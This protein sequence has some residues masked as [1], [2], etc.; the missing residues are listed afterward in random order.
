MKLKDFNDKHKG[1]T[2]FVLGN[3]EELGQLTKKQLEVISKHTTIGVNYAHL[4]HTPTYM[5]SGHFSQ[6]LYA[7]TYADI[8]SF[9]AFFFQGITNALNDYKYGLSDFKEHMKK[10]TLVDV[11]IVSLILLAVRVTT[12]SFDPDTV[13]LAPS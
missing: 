4:I 1:E 10:T 2:I 5:I 9:N 8:D 7:Q 3:G 6:I 13:R 11:K 12:F